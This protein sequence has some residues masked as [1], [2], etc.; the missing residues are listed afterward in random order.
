MKPFR[1]RVIHK[2]RNLATI[3]EK[4][5]RDVQAAWVQFAAG[6][7]QKWSEAEQMAMEGASDAFIEMMAIGMWVEYTAAQLAA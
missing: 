4:T 5:E 2:L 7:L 6:E 3:D 1:D